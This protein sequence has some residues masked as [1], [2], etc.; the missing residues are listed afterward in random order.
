MNPGKTSLTPRKRVELA[1]RGKHSDRVPFTTFEEYYVPHY[2]EA[3][4]IMHRHGKLIGCHSLM[5]SNMKSEAK[6][7]SQGAFAP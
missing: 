3:A 2:N 4:E 5:S 7:K 1:L 6:I